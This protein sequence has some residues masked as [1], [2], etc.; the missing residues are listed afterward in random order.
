M[1]IVNFQY[2]RSKNRKRKCILIL[3]SG[4]GISFHEVGEFDYL[5]LV[6]TLF[7]LEIT[8]WKLSLKIVDMQVI[9]KD[10][11]RLLGQVLS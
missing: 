11:S 4:F 2:F 3:G 8:S 5:D 6:P 9:K 7:L 10:E 1:M